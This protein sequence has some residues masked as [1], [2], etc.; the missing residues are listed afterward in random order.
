MGLADFHGPADLWLFQLLNR[1]GGAL[2]DG[3]MRTLS[4]RSFG[5]ACGALLCALLLWRLRLRAWPVLLALGLTL[6]ASDFAASQLLRP[7]IG[8]MRPCYALPP[9]TFRQLASA[10]NGPSL[11]SLHASNAF[12]LALVAS[13]AWRKLTPWV[14][15][16][17]AAI[18][19]SRVYLG[20]HWPT[21]VLAGAAWGTLAGAAGWAASAALARALRARGIRRSPSDPRHP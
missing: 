10:A 9:G 6:L 2:L 7:L 21:D 16:L 3:V 5:L 17:A 15:L 19:V 11:P 4:A 1:D 14:Y 13:F 8:R 20:V 12:A 18:A